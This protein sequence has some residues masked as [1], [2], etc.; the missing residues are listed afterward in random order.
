MTTISDL[1]NVRYGHSLELNRMT[2]ATS[3]DGIAFASRKMGDNG[4]AAFVSPIR[5][6]PPATP[7]QISVALG[8]NGVLSAFLQERPFYTGRDVAILS[9]RMAKSTT[10]ILYY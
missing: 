9:P 7:G 6:V 4:V 5:D 2:L 3:C 1:F 10:V 8:G